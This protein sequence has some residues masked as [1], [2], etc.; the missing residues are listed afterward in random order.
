MQALWIA[1][2]FKTNTMRK[3]FYITTSIALSSIIWF[4]CSKAVE[5]RTDNIPALNPVSED[6]EAGKWKLILLS[7][8]DSFAVVAPSLPGT[9]AYSADLNEIKGYQHNLTNEQKESIRY[10]GAGG[11]LRWNE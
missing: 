7:R 11:V 4:S 8:P 5:G 3:T 6:L 10:W 2:N 9:P 1:L